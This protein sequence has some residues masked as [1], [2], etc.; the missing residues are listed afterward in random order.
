MAF[1]ASLL[2]SLVLWLPS[3]L[4]SLRGDLD[5]TAAGLRYLAALTLSRFAVGVV[6][7]LLSAYRAAGPPRAESPSKPETPRRRKQDSADADADAA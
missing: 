4:A 3:V 7:R 2:L 1:S 5:M 6:A